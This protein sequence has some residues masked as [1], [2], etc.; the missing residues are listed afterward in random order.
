[1]KKMIIA[2]SAL[3]LLCSSCTETYSG[4]AGFEAPEIH[5]TAACDTTT[6]STPVA[7]AQPQAQ[8]YVQQYSTNQPLRFRLPK[9]SNIP[10]AL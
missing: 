9:K 5:T 2:L 3:A 4:Q 6:V 8:T 7:T 1:M 10:R